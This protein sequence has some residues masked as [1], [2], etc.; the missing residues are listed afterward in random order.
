MR[1]S[2]F[3]IFI[4]AAL[5][6]CGCAPH[7][8]VNAPFGMRDPNANEV[9]Y[10]AVAY[11][12]DD[13][14]MCSKISDLAVDESA[15]DMGVGNWRVTYE[16]SKCYFY[17]GIKMKSPE[18]CK[19]IRTI[20]TIPHNDSEVSREACLKLVQDSNVNGYSPSPDFFTL[21]GFME[22][23]KYTE[24]DRWAAQYS[25]SEFHTPVWLFYEQIKNDPSFI[26][27]VE[28]LP[29]YAEPFSERMLRPANPDEMLLQMVAVDNSI[30]SLCERVSPNAYYY[31]A[32]I[33]KVRIGST[34]PN[35]LKNICFGTIASNAN[36][37][38]FCAGMSPT[39]H[40][41]LSNPYLTKERCE[42]NIRDSVRAGI[43]SHLRPDTFLRMKDF[44]T[45]LRKLGY[46]QEF[47]AV[48][49]APDWS[50][51]YLHLIFH[52]DSEEKMEFLR[53]AESLPSFSN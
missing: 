28:T 18:L 41:I 3:P 21:G 43:R 36:K 35:S 14:R 15:P 17:L 1:K 24:E 47:V 37:T 11:N 25:E 23:M 9:F 40:S 19:Q 42:K 26:S 46:S 38:E 50:T 4:A 39:N 10:T 34:M 49:A 8:N 29:S 20:V 51:F 22:E 13:P 5:T 45:S 30:V 2:G 44:V 31:V 27:R 52:S 7:I 6:L 33:P 53:R 12:F 48:T 16:K 32:P